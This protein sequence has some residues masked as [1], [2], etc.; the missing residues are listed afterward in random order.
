MCL[1]LE[2]SGA[3]WG[4]KVHQKRNISLNE[5]F[6]PFLDGL[7]GR[8]GARSVWLCVKNEIIGPLPG[9]VLGR[10]RAFARGDDT[11]HAWEMG[12]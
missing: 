8:G 5:T 2:A 9:L 3:E 11:A 12:L 6:R 1:N 10:N 7:V 4:A